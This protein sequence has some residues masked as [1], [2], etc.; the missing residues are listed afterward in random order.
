MS[1]IHGAGTGRYDGDEFPLPP[2][3]PRYYSYEYRLRQT[4]GLSPEA[5]AAMI[6]RQ[7]GRCA[8]CRRNALLHVDHDHESG[9]VRGLLCRRCN[10]GL[11]Q[12][13]DDLDLLL[14]A[15]DYLK[16]AKTLRP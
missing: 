3:R 8:I 12:F 7:S 2:K 6:E 5:Y 4:Y 14:L 9:A 1:I 15:A 10:T 11:G 16:T 13:G